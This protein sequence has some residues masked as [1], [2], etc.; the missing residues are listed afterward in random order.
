MGEGDAAAYGDLLAAVCLARARQSLDAGQ[1]QEAAAE[2]QAGL[3]RARAHRD[4]RDAGAKLTSPLLQGYTPAIGEVIGTGD[5][6]A[7]F[8]SALEDPC[9]Q[10]LRERAD[11]AARF[12]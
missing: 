9:F 4:W 10:S 3:D 11:D 12:Q 7:A 8:R 1:P 6:V 5:P 2:L